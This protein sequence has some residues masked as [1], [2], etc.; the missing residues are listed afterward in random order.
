MYNKN[1]KILIVED[2]IAFA[3]IVKIQLELLGYEVTVATDAY[4]GT[5]EIIRGDYALVILDLMMPAGGGFSILERIKEFP[6]KKWTPTVIVT[7]KTIDDEV[8]AKA[9]EYNVAAIFRKPYN[10]VKFKK[11]IKS[12]VPI[13]KKEDRGSEF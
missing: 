13:R 12:L 7:G 10:N 4:R 9:E 6:G 2:E 8:R 5:E 3:E 1:K 11:K